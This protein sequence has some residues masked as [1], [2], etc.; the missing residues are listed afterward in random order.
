MPLRNV[1]LNINKILHCHTQFLFH[2]QYVAVAGV[3]TD[4]KQNT[5]AITTTI[6]DK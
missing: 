3:I 2:I 6:D 4:T 5:V 1:S